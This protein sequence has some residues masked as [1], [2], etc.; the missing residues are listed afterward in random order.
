MIYSFIMNIRF[1]SIFDFSI[2]FAFYYNGYV[3][4]IFE[5]CT[6]LSFQLLNYLINS[7]YNLCTGLRRQAFALY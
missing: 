2:P 4:L 1:L 6:A 5:L 3:C 7:N